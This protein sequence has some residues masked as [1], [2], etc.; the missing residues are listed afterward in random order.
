MQ[1]LQYLQSSH[2]L[3]LLHSLQGLKSPEKRSQ[4]L[5]NLHWSHFLHK[6][7]L[8]QRNVAGL[9]SVVRSE[10]RSVEEEDV[11]SSVVMAANTAYKTL[12]KYL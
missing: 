2:K 12:Y 11:S 5:Q 3:H 4:I 8:L 6:L 7:H 1:V 10:V 9:V